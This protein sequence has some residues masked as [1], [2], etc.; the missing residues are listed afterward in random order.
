VYAIYW[1]I[2]LAYQTGF[3][4]FCSG[5]TPGCWIFGV[6][7][8]MKDGQRLSWRGALGRTLAG[9]VIGQLPVVGH[10]LRFLD[11]MAALFNRRRMA[12]RDMAAGTMLIHAS[13]WWLPSE[14]TI[15]G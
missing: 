7:V 9:G 5:R 13:K 14:E 4:T 2:K 10:V 6:R 12:L 11:Y 3:L 1:G 8:V 15:H